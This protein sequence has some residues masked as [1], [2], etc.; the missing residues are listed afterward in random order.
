VNQDDVV[1]FPFHVP[2]GLISIPRL[3]IVI[4]WDDPDA[5]PNAQPALVNDIDLILIDP[6]LQELRPWV[7]DPALPSLPAVRG[8]DSLNNVENVSVDSPA[9]GQWIARVT[10]ANVPEGPQLVSIVGFDLDAPAM[11]DSFTVANPTATSLELTWIDDRPVDYAGTLVARLDDGV[12]W[13]GP[14]N[15]ESFLEGQ[16]VES[17]VTVI[18]QRTEDHST[19]PFVDQGLLPDTTYQYVAYS[20]DDARTYSPAATGEGATQSVAS[21]EDPEAE[22]VFGL[23][24]PHPNPA[25]GGG[26][27]LTFGLSRSGSARLRVFDPS[28]RLVRTLVDATLPAGAHVTSWDGRDA[29]GRLVPSGVYFYE[30]RSSGERATRQISWIR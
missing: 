23:G 25:N 22:Y 14:A 21:A 16:I 6:N 9:A 11:P 4:A 13:D 12:I 7:L 20:F 26:V 3:T 24:T 5:A 27:G 2:G 19:T 28:G 29:A 30:L 10:G 17:G 18:Y 8:V 1:E 15:G